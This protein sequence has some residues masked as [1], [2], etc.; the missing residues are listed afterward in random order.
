MARSYRRDAQGRFS[1][2]ASAAP[3][4]MRTKLARTVAPLG[5]ISKRRSSRELNRD[6]YK[7]KEEIGN[8]GEWIG[9]RRPRRL[10][11]SPLAPA[12]LRKSSSGKVGAI[13]A[14]GRRRTGARARRTAT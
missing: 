14:A 11:G 12:K 13:A 7:G 2:G 10:P 8:A 1:G 4:T 6:A 9:R 5:T 3:S